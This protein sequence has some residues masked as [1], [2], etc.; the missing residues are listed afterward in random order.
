VTAATTPRHPIRFRVRS[1]HAMVLAPEP[2]LPVW[3]AAFDAWLARSPGFFNGRPVVLDLSALET[4]KSA[5]SELIK[6]LVDRNIRVMGIEGVGPADLDPLMPPILSGAAQTER[7]IDIVDIVDH[8][9]R[10][11]RS[12]PNTL[13][14]D[15]PVRSGQCIGN[16]NGDVII[17]GSVASGAEIIAGGSIHIYGTLRGRAI[18]GCES[19]SARIFCR[20]LEAELVSIDGHYMTADEMGQLFRGRPVQIWLDGEK[21]MMM[22]ALD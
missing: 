20:K 7:A 21:T 3:F 4:S 11:N 2:P 14:I 9:V 22:T 13:L 16:P 10:E 1:V 12:R 18:A 17:V 5:L 8:S 19:P 6:D 15:S